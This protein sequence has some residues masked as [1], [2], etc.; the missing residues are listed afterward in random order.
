M[1]KK[2]IVN[3]DGTNELVDLTPEE[4]AERVE[5]QKLLAIELE[6]IEQKAAQRSALLERLGIT[7]DEAKLLLA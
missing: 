3:V 4:I 5:A 7:E 1:S 2:L 6:L